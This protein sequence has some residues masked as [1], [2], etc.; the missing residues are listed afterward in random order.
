[1]TQGKLQQ[2]EPVIF[3]TLDKKEKPNNTKASIQHLLKL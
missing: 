2:M 3:F 1:M